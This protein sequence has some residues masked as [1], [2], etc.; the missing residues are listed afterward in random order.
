MGREEQPID[1]GE[2]GKLDRNQNQ[3]IAPNGPWQD[4]GSGLRVGWTPAGRQETD[5]PGGFHAA[6][7]FKT[8]I[9]AL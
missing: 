3:H 8:T 2:R 9:L 6:G 1:G 4:R 5:Q 7:P